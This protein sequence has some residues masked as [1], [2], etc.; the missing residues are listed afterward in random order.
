MLTVLGEIA[1]TLDDLVLD[2]SLEEVR[3]NGTD[4][5]FVA[6]GGVSRAVPM[7]LSAM[8]IRGFVERVLRQ[9]GRRVD[10]SSPFVDASLPDGSRLHVVIPDIT[11]ALIESSLSPQYSRQIAASQSS[12]LGVPT[13]EV[14]IVA[15]FP[16]VGLW[17]VGGVMEVSA[18]APLDYAR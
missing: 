2:P 4:Q 13:I 3:I 16:A 7:S 14:R 12:A 5:V 10:V 1:P 15:P 11:K 8:E 18:H 6:E 9:T 17:S